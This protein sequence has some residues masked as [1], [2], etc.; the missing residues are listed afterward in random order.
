MVEDLI[1]NISTNLTDLAYHG[2]EDCSGI[3]ASFCKS[4]EGNIDNAL[5]VMSAGIILMIL[6][7]IGKKFNIDNVFMNYLYESGF[8]ELLLI[9]GFL[10]MTY[11]RFLG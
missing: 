2:F 10:F 1:F 7:N 3:K 5:L 6:R 8:P 4:L 9:M 11:I